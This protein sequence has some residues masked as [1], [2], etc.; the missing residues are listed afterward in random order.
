VAAKNHNADPAKVQPIP[1]GYHTATPYLIVKNAAAAIEFYTRAFGAKET[2]RMAGPDGKMMHAEMKIGDSI[3]M[4]SDEF[5]SHQALSPETLGG[6]PMFVVLYVEDVDARVRQALAAGAKV[7][8]PVEDQFFGD[9]SG[10]VLDPFGHRWTL[11]THIEDV[12]DAEMERRFAAIMGTA[13]AGG[14]ASSD[15]DQ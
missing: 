8:R 12:S 1:A 11:T 5:P 15:K 4:L 6:S 10:T 14:S 9:R 3:V 7:L 13:A 2:R